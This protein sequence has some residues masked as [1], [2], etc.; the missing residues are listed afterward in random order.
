M[1]RRRALARPRDGKGGRTSFVCGPHGYSLDLVPRRPCNSQSK[2]A[3]HSSEERSSSPLSLASRDSSPFQGEQMSPWRSQ[4]AYVGQSRNVT[5]MSAAFGARWPL[6]R[7]FVPLKMRGR[8]GLVLN[9]PACCGVVLGRSRLLLH[10]PPPSFVPQEYSPRQRGDITQNC[11]PRCEVLRLYRRL[12]Q[13]RVACG[14]CRGHL[15]LSSRES[16]R[17][18]ATATPMPPMIAKN[19]A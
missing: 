15:H 6:R 12:K 5:P 16:R 2:N 1:A 4:C 7:N 3:K 17:L 9:N 8:R 13:W 14:L 10:Q 19:K 11:R 18:L